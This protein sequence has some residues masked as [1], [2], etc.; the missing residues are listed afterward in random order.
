MSTNLL[1]KEEAKYVGVTA[2]ELIDKN[3]M[4][5]IVSLLQNMHRNFSLADVI[6]Y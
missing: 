6:Y 1:S 2:A 5:S 3:T 4:K